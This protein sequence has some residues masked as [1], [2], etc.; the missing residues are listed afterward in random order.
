MSDGDA[1]QLLK[2]NPTQ[3]GA[4]LSMAYGAGLR[5]ASSTSMPSRSVRPCA[6]PRHSVKP[7]AISLIRRD[8][9][10]WEKMGNDQEPPAFGVVG[11]CCASLDREPFHGV[12]VWTGDRGARGDGH[13]LPDRATGR[14]SCGWMVAAN[15]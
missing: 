15:W 2:Q 12:P 1:F 9:A 11:A 3:Y 10:T 6:Q 14:R 7:L 5:A 4:V 8:G 13:A